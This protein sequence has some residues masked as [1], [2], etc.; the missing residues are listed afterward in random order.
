MDT[1]TGLNTP[2]NQLRRRRKLTL[3]NVAAKLDVPIGTVGAWFSYRHP[4]SEK[5]ISL[6]AEILKISPRNLIKL[7]PDT[8]VSNIDLSK[9]KRPYHRKVSKSPK[10]VNYNEVLPTI[11]GKIPMIDYVKIYDDPHQL[12]EYGELLYGKVSCS[13]YCM[14]FL[15]N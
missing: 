4:I 7:L 12:C 2:L 15:S 1:T 3:A 6:I 5:Y 8:Q 10:S 11:Y 14:L 13:Q 9:F